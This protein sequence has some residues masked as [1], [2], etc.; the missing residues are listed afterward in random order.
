[1]T[2]LKIEFSYSY[3]GLTPM[4]V[5]L[6]FLNSSLTFAASKFYKSFMS[7]VDFVSITLFLLTVLTL[8]LVIPILTV[9]TDFAK[10]FSLNCEDLYDDI[11]ETPLFESNV[12]TLESLW[13]GSV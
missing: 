3:E 12:G 1:M 2:T 10:A 4:G 7:L 8:S 11:C 6:A 5:R 9:S 13:T